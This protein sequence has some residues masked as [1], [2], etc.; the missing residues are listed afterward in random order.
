MI[1]R[2]IPVRIL[3]I[4]II[5]AALFNLLALMVM[6]HTTPIIFTLFMFIGQPLFVLAFVLLVGAVLA[7]LKARQLL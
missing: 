5:L 1:P 6:L 3:R 7:D 2:E 4:A